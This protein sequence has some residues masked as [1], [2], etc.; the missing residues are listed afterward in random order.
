LARPGAQHDARTIVTQFLNDFEQARALGGLY[1]LSYHSQLLA[2][3]D[4]VPVLASV[5]RSIAA[6]SGVWVAT[7]SE[8]ATW[9]RTRASL[10][11]ETRTRGANSLDVIVHNGGAQS[12]SGA[13]GRV[14]LPDQRRALDASAPLLASD[15]GVVRLALPPLPGSTTQ[16]FTV[17]LAPG[18]AP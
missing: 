18:R 7:T 17:R 11:I 14:V 4:L 2:R 5:A 13:V 12:L 10:R 3:P 15:P 16:S 1:V 8:I 9:W 6:D